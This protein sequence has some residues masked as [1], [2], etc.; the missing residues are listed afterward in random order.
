MKLRIWFGMVI[1]LLIVSACGSPIEE[2]MSRNVDQMTT[3]NQ[4]G[5]EVKLPEDFKGDYW[6][7][8]FIFTNCDTVCP[9]MTGNMSR[10][11]NQLKEENL[12]VPL[13]SVS[14]DPKNDTPEE[15]VAFSKDYQP[16]YEQ[17][18]FLTGYTFQEVKEWSIKSFQSP[19][20]KLPDSNQVAH[21]T[22]F[23][24][25]TPEGEVIKSYSGTDADSVTKI[26]E[27]L[28]TLKK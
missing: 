10:L 28:K 12:E 27:D 23:Y 13:V 17:W 4:H 6:I 14:V 15:L 8:D 26:V 3:V 22:S 11:Q 25:V 7:A 18:D 19:L 1:L 21:G 5:N 9:P 24:L 16:D 20:K 2:N